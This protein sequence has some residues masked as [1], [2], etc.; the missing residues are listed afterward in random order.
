[1]HNNRQ[2]IDGVS[3]VA[4]TA[5]FGI[6]AF[7]ACNPA[8]AL[9][10]GT[11]GNP[12]ALG[13]I[14]GTSTGCKAVT[15]VVS[16]GACTTY[17]KIIPLYTSLGIL[18]S[19]QL[20][21]PGSCTAVPTATVSVAA[22]IIG[23]VVPLG[24]GRYSA[25]YIPTLKRNDAVSFHDVAVSQAVSGGLMATYYNDVTAANTAKQIRSKQTTFGVL[26][27]VAL[28][29]PLSAIT[30]T[31]S[32]FIGFFKPASDACT[33]TLTASTLKAQI[34]GRHYTVVA[35]GTATLTGLVVNS[36][37]DIRFELTTAAGALVADINCIPAAEITLR[38]FAVHDLAF[39]TFRGNGLFATYYT[40]A[41]FAPATYIQDANL[42][43]SGASKTNRPYPEI[44]YDT[45]GGAFSARWF[46]FV[47][48]SRSDRYTF[49]I[50]AK[51]PAASSVSL[52]V[53][54]VLVIATGENVDGTVEY[55][56]TIQFTKAHDWYSIEM[57]YAVAAGK[58]S[59][60]FKLSWSNDGY[61]LSAFADTFVAPLSNETEIGR[62]H[63]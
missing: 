9:T 56:G 19:F 10:D 32:R 52:Y 45:A 8:I 15:V 48:P 61:S 22:D 20:E 50:E 16:G 29:G 51:N 33:F 14:T 21:N 28:D 53:D 31:R 38:Y 58:E 60:G 37:Y 35:P 27:E 18:S 54:G 6:D 2:A 47:K 23:T 7:L 12:V 63:V 11:G 30:P 49:F 39:N 24:D 59:R 17:P 44:P 43:W 25:S 36:L 26:A 5:T 62:A 41:A 40:G 13:A 46:G 42:D 57:R 1:M 3:A 4:G 34:N 55:S